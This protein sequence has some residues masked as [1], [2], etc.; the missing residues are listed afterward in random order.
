MQIAQDKNKYP[1]SSNI[2]QYPS[3]T[4]VRVFIESSYLQRPTK[5]FTF[6]TVDSTT[7]KGSHPEGRRRPPALRILVRNLAVAA[8]RARQPSPLDHPQAKRRETRSVFSPRGWCSTGTIHRWS[9]CSTSEGWLSVGTVRS[10]YLS[11]LPTAKQESK[12]NSAKWKAAK[13][14]PRARNNQSNSTC[15]R[16]LASPQFTSTG[17][18]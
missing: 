16:E 8:C 11:Q 5:Q 13:Q 15:G 4:S 1:R 7:S 6:Y 2:H 12:T 18:A 9:S 14:S 17:T 3:S 10:T